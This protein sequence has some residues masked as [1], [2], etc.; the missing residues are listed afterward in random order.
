MHPTHTHSL[1]A[2]LA[3]GNLCKPILTALSNSHTLFVII[4]ASL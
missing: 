2:T 3:F 1:H 4:F